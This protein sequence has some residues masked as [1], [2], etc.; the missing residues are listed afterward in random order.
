MFMHRVIMVTLVIAILS[1]YDTSI[2]AGVTMSLSSRL[3]DCRG[4]A[5]AAGTAN[6]GSTA[7]AGEWSAQSIGRMAWPREE[8]LTASCYIRT[9]TRADQS[10]VQFT[11]CKGPVLYTRG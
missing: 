6:R 7:P 5:G 2:H 3:S 11:C 9:V 8:H 1:S 4:P 10:S